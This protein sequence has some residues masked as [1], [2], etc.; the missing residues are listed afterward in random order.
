[1]RNFFDR[2]VTMATVLSS[3]ATTNSECFDNFHNFTS[4]SSEIQLRGKCNV[5]L[6]N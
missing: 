4:L 5:R 3:M 1:M 2:L 6:H